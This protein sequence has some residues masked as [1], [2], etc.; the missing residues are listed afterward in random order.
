MGL[1]V[2]KLYV[3]TKPPSVSCGVEAWRGENQLRCHPRHL[4][5]VQSL[6]R[7]VPTQVPSSSSDRGSKLRGLSQNSPGIASKRDAIITNLT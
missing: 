6:E 1:V 5:A 2:H 7:R 3:A 4:T